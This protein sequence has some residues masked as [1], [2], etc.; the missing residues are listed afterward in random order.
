VSNYE[1]SV[2]TT[3]PEYAP[4][5]ECHHELDC[6]L[7]MLISPGGGIPISPG[8]QAVHA[9]Y[10]AIMRRMADVGLLRRGDDGFYLSIPG[11]LEFTLERWTRFD[12]VR[13][14]LEL[15]FVSEP[16]VFH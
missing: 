9:C 15:R 7:D 10:R 6:Y 5:R 4:Y 12:T 11:Q 14:N 2:S 3:F 13:Y 16:M 8:E 1:L